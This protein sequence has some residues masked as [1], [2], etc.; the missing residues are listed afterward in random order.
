M[1]SF[2]TLL[3]TDSIRHLSQDKQ[4]NFVGILIDLSYDNS[5]VKGIEHAFKLS[6]EIDRKILSDKNFTVLNYYLANGWS[7]LRKIKFQNTTDDWNFQMIE[8]TNEISHLRIAISSTGFKKVQKERQSQIYTNLGNLF[9]Y[10]GRFVEAQDY[11]NKAINIIPQFSIAIYNK[12]NGL[13]HYGNYLFDELHKN[14]FILFSY[15]YFKKALLYKDHLEQGV[16]KHVREMYNYID[17]RL[18]KKFK[19]SVPDLNGFDL[20]N[21][22]ELKKYRKWCLESKLYINPLNDLGNFS[23]ACHDCLNLPTL[24]MN[25]KEPPKWIN[26]YNQIKQEFGTARY[27]YYYSLQKNGFHFSDTDVEIIETYENANYS[28]YIE[29]VKIAFRMS[30][31]ILDKIAFLLNDYLCL[32]IKSDKIS[33]KNFWYIDFKGKKLRSFF[34][35]SN[36]WALRGLYWLSKDLYEKE[37]DFN[38]IIEPDARELALIRNHIE[39]KGFKIITGF[40]MPLNIYDNESDISYTIFRKD[41]EEKTM[42]I[43]K[44]ARSAIMYLSLAIYYEESKKDY[45]NIKTIPIKSTIVPN[46]IKV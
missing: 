24:V 3:K 19:Q 35:E 41:F 25:L 6:K 23:D 18:G 37:N 2:E 33:F 13:F 38:S 44:I 21:N 26:L 34:K 31:S 1:A 39:H 27:S 42:K 14:I 29:Q 17:S 4:I 15:Q 40:K 12:A 46:Y 10:I 11:W 32:N 22:D 30:Y 43:L 7:C 20:G 16:E 28:Y 9:S 45:S 36:N 5:S 8:I